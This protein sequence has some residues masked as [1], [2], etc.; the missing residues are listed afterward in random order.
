[1]TG[2]HRNFKSELEF[3]Y[4]CLV[5]DFSPQDEKKFPLSLKIFEVSL[6]KT[7]GVVMLRAGILNWCV[8]PTEVLQL[9]MKSQSWFDCR[10]VPAFDSTSCGLSQGLMLE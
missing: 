3:T 9:I 4:R 7:G 10:V 5:R 8:K 1:M 2:N 6:I